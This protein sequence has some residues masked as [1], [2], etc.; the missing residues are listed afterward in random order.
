MLRLCL[1]FLLVISFSTC[2]EKKLKP[3][4]IDPAFA[5]Y[6]ISFTSGVISS[7]SPIR[8]RMVQEQASAVAGEELKDNPFD[9]SPNIEGKAVWID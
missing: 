3:I 7:A 2:G 4:Y 1:A 8:V 5:E 6:I 9:F